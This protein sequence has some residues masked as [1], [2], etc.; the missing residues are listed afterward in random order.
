MLRFALRVML[1]A[2]SFAAA[3]IALGWWTVPLLGAA[4]P[5]IDRDDIGAPRTAA[6]AAILGWGALLTW[7]ATYP[8]FGLLGRRL[9]GVLGPPVVLLVAATLLLAAALAWGAATVVSGILPSTR[10]C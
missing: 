5:I 8:A 3:T 6:L 1:L 10:R 2:A 9:S 7:D 4:W